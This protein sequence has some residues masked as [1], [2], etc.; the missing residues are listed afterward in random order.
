MLNLRI[1]LEFL[2]ENKYLGSLICVHTF[3]FYLDPHDYFLLESN[4]FAGM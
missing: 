2:Y 4:S 3:I 1:L